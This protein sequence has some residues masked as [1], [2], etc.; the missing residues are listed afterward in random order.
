MKDY[1]I[2]KQSP[3]TPGT[4]VNPKDFVGRE[5]IISDI[6]K[7]I[8]A[9]INGKNRNFYIVGNRG[10]GKSSLAYY[11]ADLLKENYSIIPVYISNEGINDLNS[12][13]FHLVQDLLNKIGNKNWADQMTFSTVING[14]TNLLRVRTGRVDIEVHRSV[15]RRVAVGSHTAN[16][17]L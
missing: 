13:M 12:L 17:A 3:F 7:Y 6:I 2:T 16:S 10:M 5:E 8:P 15:D 4:M 14:R 9:I 11:L 1:K